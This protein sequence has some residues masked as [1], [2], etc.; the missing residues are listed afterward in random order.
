ML[1]IYSRF[2]V[3]FNKRQNARGQSIR[4]IL[5]RYGDTA[6]RGAHG[7]WHHNAKRHGGGGDDAGGRKGGRCEG[8]NDVRSDFPE[9]GAVARRSHPG[10]GLKGGIEGGD[11]VEA[12]FGAD[13]LERHVGLKV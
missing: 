9:L 7:D 2:G 4:Y 12:D 5:Y 3:V 6:I 13:L 1:K 8:G 11:G 10:D